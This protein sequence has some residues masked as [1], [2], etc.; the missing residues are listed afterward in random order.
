MN[1]GRKQ[2]ANEEAAR[3]YEF[4]WLRFILTMAFISLFLAGCAKST[5]EQVAEQLELGNRYLLEADYE[6]AV[7]AFSKAIELDPKNADGYFG[8]GQAREGQAAAL[9]ADSRDQGLEY[10]RLAAE[11]YE[12]VLILSPQDVRPGNHLIAIYKELGDTEKYLEALNLF[13]IDGTS[14]KP[15]QLKAYAD[16]ITQLKTLCAEEDYD[17]IF[18]LMQESSFEELEA[19]VLDTGNPVII[20]HEG[21]GLGLY[22]VTTELYGSCMVYY[23]QYSGEKRQGNGLWLGGDS[24][25]NH[26]AKGEWMDDLPNGAFE[27][28]YVSAQNVEAGVAA[29]LV[30][31][32]VVNGLWN[33]SVQWNFVENDGEVW[34]YPVNFTNGKWVI[35]RYRDDGGAVVSEISME[36]GAASEMV[37]AIPE[38]AV[39]IVGFT[40]SAEIEP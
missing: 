24:G 36:D 19:F 10:Y 8:M 32:S 5:A 6:G 25:N 17:S 21:T 13:A 30:T 2:G 35:L 28:R 18:S 22:P 33:G 26:Y 40:Q 27:A 11:A 1:Q 7:V 38:R 31:G 16:C 15:E 3:V 4:R 23:G 14:R 29:E 39:G 37:N 12:Q 20:V 34:T 9:L